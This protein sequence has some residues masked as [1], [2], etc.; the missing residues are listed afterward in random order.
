VGSGSSAG[1]SSSSSSIGGWVVLAPENDLVEFIVKTSEHFEGQV[2]ET[3]NGVVKDRAVK[4]VPI[5][6]A[7]G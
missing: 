5:V 7:R 4:T 6:I 1:L 2:I 3:S